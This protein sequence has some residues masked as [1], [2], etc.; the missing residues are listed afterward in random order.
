MIM[1]QTKVRKRENKASCK[2]SGEPK[3][4]KSV[5]TEQHDVKDEWKNFASTD[6]GAKI[7][8]SSSNMKH[9]NH[10]L[11]R[12]EDEYLLYTC[13]QP[14]FFVIELCENVKLSR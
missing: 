10:V 13:D 4:V 9:P 3:Q 5:A 1:T 2:V 11:N 8:R 7:I 6:C 12:N 14:A